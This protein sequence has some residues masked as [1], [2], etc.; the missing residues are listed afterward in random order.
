MKKFNFKNY[1]AFTLTEMTLVLL[2]T[3]VIAAASTPI[4]TSA[5]SD[6]APTP[7]EMTDV[8]WKMSLN[9]T[10]GAIYNTPILNKSFISIGHAP[11]ADASE[12]DYP[13][14]VVESKA[15]NVFEP[16]ITMLPYPGFTNDMATEPNALVYSN[17]G[18]DEYDNFAF[19]YASFS[20]MRS[21]SGYFGSRSVYLGSGIQNSIY[22]TP[23]RSYWDKSIFIGQ[24][25]NS[26]YASNAVNIG[27]AH[28]RALRESNTVNI[29][30]NN[31]YGNYKTLPHDDVVD[32]GQN[33]G[34]YAYGNYDIHIGTSYLGYYSKT[35]RCVM[36]GDHT[37][38]YMGFN[39]YSNVD[40]VLIGRM[41]GYN[42]GSYYTTPFKNNIAIGYYA[43][44]VARTTDFSTL[45]GVNY[46]R[47]CIMIGDN[48][49]MY[50]YP[51]K[52][53]VIR[54]N[55]IMI[56]ENAGVYTNKNHQSIGPIAINSMYLGYRSGFWSYA[57]SDY[58][59]YNP[60]IFIGFDSGAYAVNTTNSILIGTKAGQYATVN[61]TIA[62]GNLAGY[63]NTGKRVSNSIFI[64]EKAGYA[65]SSNA[66]NIVGVGNFTAMSAKSNKMFFGYGTFAM[67]NLKNY[68]NDK[69]VFDKDNENPGI[70]IGFMNKGIKGQ[71]ITF[72]ASKVYR[73]G[74]G[75]ITQAA[76]NDTGGTY[77][78]SDRRF[79]KDI[80]L[81]KR[82]L[83][84][85]RKINIYDY[86]FKKDI[87]KTPRIGIIA[88]EYRKIFPHDVSREPSSNKL[89]A[90][91]D[92]LIYTMVNAVKDVDKEVQTLKKD[93]DD[94]ISGF[95]GLKSKVEKLEKQAEQIKLDNEQMK[96]RLS[97]INE[98]LK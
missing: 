28:S 87:N 11:G 66:Q 42:Y 80:V 60:N 6:G 21:Y 40:N 43:G 93:M 19:T 61:D 49:G 82:S 89:A 13:A 54:S 71:K 22:N 36:F 26:Y 56:G 84:D 70:V 95:M 20:Q 33:A 90:S 41:A 9:Y 46:F 77:K 86:N 34:Y 69:V 48:T 44:S 55:S 25:I 15:N 50:K 27:A 2:I 64:G 74:T 38:Y 37:G 51:Q 96:A 59:S 45:G 58:A 14:L 63:N 68:N 1:I 5:V 30:Y 24:N 65:I 57:N 4:I 18:A 23:N 7:A 76:G 8:P 75:G 10:G 97:K 62:I 17:I 85:I 88:Q 94:Y 92:W 79:K 3:S 32:I 98:K 72:Y 81:S 78:L 47:D 67:Q 12:Y 52:P 53:Y 16:H 91:A 83:K 35:G 73:I 31:S 39:A 29:G